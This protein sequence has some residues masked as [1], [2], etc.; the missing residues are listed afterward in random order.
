[1]TLPK[2]LQVLKDNYDLTPGE[3]WRMAGYSDQQREYLM[4]LVR[5]RVK[6]SLNIGQDTLISWM[7]ERGLFDER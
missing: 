5:H 4:S 7:A 6:T 2:Y 1:M 3:A